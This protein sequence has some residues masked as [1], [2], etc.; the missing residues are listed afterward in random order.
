MTIGTAKPTP[1]ELDAVHHHFINNLSI[2]DDYDAG[3]YESEAISLLNQLFKKQSA[4]ILCG[5]SGMYIDAVCKGFDALPRIDEKYRITLNSL[6]GEDGITALQ[7]LLLEHDPDHYHNVDLN[8]PHRLI[9][10]LEI[11]LATGTPYS[12]FRKGEVKTRNFKVIK[13]GLHTDRHSLYSRINQRVDR[14]MEEGLLEEARTLYPFRELNALRTVGYK[15]LFDH[16]EGKTSLP[17]AIELI[18][19]NSRNFS[20]RQMTWFRKDKEIVWMDPSKEINLV[21]QILN[22]VH[23]AE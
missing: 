5:G 19:Q 9:R 11:T 15:E 12:A 3:K 23:S 20:K 8:N 6:F 4:L 21:A 1:K 13:I 2:H 16:L 7:T 14:M 18:K 17:A 22:Q 10:A